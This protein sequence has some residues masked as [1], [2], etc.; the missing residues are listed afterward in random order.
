GANTLSGYVYLAGTAGIGV[1]QDV[2]GYPPAPVAPYPASGLTITGSVGETGG[3]GGL[4]KLGAKRLAL[5]GDGWYS[6]NVDVRAGALRVQ[7]NTA[8]G[9]G[10]ATTTVEAGAA[11]ELDGSNPADTALVQAGPEIGPGEHLVL[12]GLGNTTVNGP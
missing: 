12:N 7:T 1:D 4:V 10:N 11:L 8:L 5:D 3:I 2:T 9:L 6:G